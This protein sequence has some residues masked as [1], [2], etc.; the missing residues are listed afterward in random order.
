MLV[1]VV[2]P[3][4]LGIIMYSLGLGLR[5][6]DFARVAQ[7]PKAFSV[8]ALNQLLVVP[9]VGYGVVVLL[10]LPP[11]LAV[12]FMILAFC[13]GGVLTN[14]MTK[15][16]AGNLPLSISLTA[17]IS[18]VSIVTVPLL[19]AWAVQHFM[20]AEAPP[21]D[22]TRLG[23]SMFL[24]TAV[25]VALGMVTTWLAPRFVERFAPAISKL[26]FVF[27]VLLIVAALAANWKVF[28]QYFPVL[29]PGLIALNVLL[30]V[31]GVVTARVAS[32]GER[33]AATIA[34]ESG[35]QNGSLGIAVATLI[36]VQPEGLPVFALPTAIYGV[37]TWIA[38]GPFVLWYRSRLARQKA[39]DLGGSA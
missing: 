17:V 31:I 7:F 32:L 26:A 2:L 11:E 36:A 4:I 14:V 28:V 15:V 18:L 20:G 25:P 23:V 39:A 19:V 1:Q 8:G 10:K 5:P 33:D 34:L 27:F 13:P 9:L 37:T 29:G 6:V 22:V 30:L 38:S 35:I 24:L 12:G 21:I 3:I 16:V